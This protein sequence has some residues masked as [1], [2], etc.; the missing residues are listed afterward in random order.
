MSAFTTVYAVQTGYVEHSTEEQFTQGEPNLV[1]ISSEGELNL[2]QSST[3]LL[4]DKDDLW[5]VNALVKAPDGTLYAAS[6]GQ[7]YIYQIKPGK[8]A[9]IFYG[10]DQQDQRHVFSLA[11]DRNNALLAGAGGRLLRLDAKGSAKELFADDEIKYIWN[12]AVGPAG[13]IY[14]ATGPTGK[15]ITLDANGKKPEVLYQA[16]EKN[17]LCIALDADG[18]VYAGGDENGLIY[19]IDPATKKARIV[20]DTEH[21]ELS[22]LVFDEKGNLYAATA[23][24]G[25]ARPGKK[26]ILSDGRDGRSEAPAIKKEKKKLSKK[27]QLPKESEDKKSTSEQ[28]KKIV[29][30][31]T[32]KMNS[33]NGK[34]DEAAEP[35]PMTLPSRKKRRGK[36]GT[37]DVY[38]ISPQGY[39]TKIFSKPL[40]IL[41]MEYVGDDTLLLATGNDGQLLQLNTETEEAVVL[42]S[43]KPSAQVSALCAS[44]DGEIYVGCANPGAVHLIS[45]DFATGGQFTS[46]VIDATQISGWGKVELEADMPSD[47]AVKIATRSG[48]TQEPDKGGWEDWSS[49]QMVNGTMTI[50]SAPGRFLQYRLFLES[51]DEGATPMVK[52][53]KLA[54]QAPNLPPKVTDVQV[55]RA[56]TNKKNGSAAKSSN[57]SRTITVKW[58]ASDANDDKLIYNVYIRQI[59]RARWIRIAKELDKT[60][61][62]FN[63]LTTADSRYEFK[64]EASDAQSNPE[65]RALTN[66]RI[67]GAIVVDNTPPEISELSWQIDSKKVTLRAVLGD[68]L[69]AIDSVIYCIDSAEDW[70]VA[71]AADGIFDSR[72]ESVELEF[73]LEESGEH[74]LAICFADALGNKVYRNI[75]IEAE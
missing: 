15:V 44:D 65:G 63:S 64:V 1:L 39:V 22:S 26:L 13:R 56:G 21:G 17:I 14:L 11:L 46:E 16:K 45:P 53:V 2:A 28:T 43:V 42:Q 49:P 57:P 24:A 9:K 36:A 75:T 5:V 10:K 47:T 33:E 6:S 61:L 30:A 31:A 59:D 19:R 62:E 73:E 12:I 60:N 4:A 34:T 71:S 51:A 32:N 27:E 25:A 54:Y 48:N 3:E 40:V 29:P 18:I 41:A 68:E 69:S 74:L 35:A 58:K 66:S 50:D 37:N 67:S 8:K 7:G 72:G 20:Y 52:K 23:D 55:A 70:Q 38:K